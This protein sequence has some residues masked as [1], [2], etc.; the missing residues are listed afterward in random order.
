M[1]NHAGVMP[2]PD[3]DRALRNNRSVRIS[4]FRVKTTLAVLDLVDCLLGITIV[5][6]IGI[7]AFRREWFTIIRDFS[8]HG[9]GSEV[10]THLLHVL[11]TSICVGG[12]F[13]AS[14]NNQI[15]SPMCM[16][17]LLIILQLQYLAFFNVENRIATLERKL[18]AVSSL[19]P[20]DHS[21][22]ELRQTN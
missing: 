20:T 11:I 9:T 1:R 18:A 14:W 15:E 19:I 21:T 8:K 4:G 6:Y 22:D 3:R 16:I 10:M 17:V 2:Y 7:D 13:Y 12:C 5:A